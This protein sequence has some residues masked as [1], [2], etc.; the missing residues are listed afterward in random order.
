MDQT[1]VETSAT[2]TTNEK[3]DDWTERTESEYEQLKLLLETT[4][5]EKESLLYKIE[6]LEA[7]NER[8]KS[9]EGYLM[10]EVTSAENDISQHKEKERQ[11]TDELE[12]MKFRLQIIESTND[13]DLDHANEN[14]EE[15]K[16]E[17]EKR[18]KQQED[19]DQESLHSEKEEQSSW[20]QKYEELFLVKFVFFFLKPLF[21]K[22]K[23]KDNDKLKKKKKLQKIHEEMSKDYERLKE[24]HA[25]LNER[26]QGLEDD[27]GRVMEQLRHLVSMQVENEQMQLQ[28]ERL[29]RKSIE[30]Y[31]PTDGEKKKRGASRKG[32]VKKNKTSNIY[33]QVVFC[34]VVRGAKQMKSG[35]EGAGMTVINRFRTKSI[36]NESVSYTRHHSNLGD[37][38]LSQTDFFEMTPGVDSEFL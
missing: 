10:M 7:D 21:L 36:T 9:R 12:T 6:T 38:R 4:K 13:E 14:E 30:M 35:Q 1:S 5:Q 24:E 23:K 11:L 29:K 8:L 27:N 15:Q 3:D 31:H 25:M 22:K 33:N 18:A 37:L 16:Q 20:Q 19:H 2:E 26:T 28:L 17:G 34:F 32:H